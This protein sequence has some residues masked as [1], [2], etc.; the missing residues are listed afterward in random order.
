LSDS[1]TSDGSSWGGSQLEKAEQSYLRYGRWSLLL[2]WVPIIGD[3]LTVVAG[4]MREPFWSFL[5]IVTLA[6]ALSRSLN[7][8][9]ECE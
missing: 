9:L 2:S 3:P 8:T 6:R 5:L 4:V 1:A 7:A